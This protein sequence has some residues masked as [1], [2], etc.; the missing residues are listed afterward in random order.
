M[1]R[2]YCHIFGKH[3]IIKELKGKR[4]RH[5]IFCSPALHAVFIA[6]FAVASALPVFAQPRGDYEYSSEWLYG[7]TKATNSGLIGGFM[8]RHS[9]QLKKENHFHGFGLEIVNIKH[10]QEQ[11]YYS[12]SGNTFIWGKEHYLYS[13]RMAYSREIVLFHKAPQQGVQISALVSAGPTLGLEAPYYLEIL[14][15]NN[16]T[17]RV[18]YDHTNPQHSYENIVGTGTLFQGLFQSSVVPGLNTRAGMVFEFGTFRSSVIGVEV[19]FQSDWFP[20]EI[21]I[22]PTTINYS[23]FPNAYATLFYGSRR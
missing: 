7:I 3:A 17:A 4:I 19:G 5:G 22:M 23:F 10:P 15:G 16:Q 13:I 14:V 21:L 12:Q 8:L 1:N 9:R 18:P 20:R 2:C 11:R 6:L